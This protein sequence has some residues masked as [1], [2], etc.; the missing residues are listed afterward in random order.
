MWGLSG[1]WVV[2]VCDG[3]RVLTVGHG[4]AAGETRS[5]STS[6]LRA[7]T[8][9]LPSGTFVEVMRVAAVVDLLVWEKDQVEGRLRS[10]SGTWPIGA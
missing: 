2:A 5:S 4:G 1:E 6:G 10:Q 8:V 3:R 9:T 7:V